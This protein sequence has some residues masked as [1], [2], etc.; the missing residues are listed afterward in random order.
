MIANDT[1]TLLGQLRELCQKLA[2]NDAYNGVGSQANA[3]SGAYAPIITFIE[4]YNETLNDE[5]RAMIPAPLHAEIRR[6]LTLAS[7]PTVNINATQ[8]VQ[9]CIADNRTRLIAAMTGQE[10]ILNAISVTGSQRLEYLT[11]ARSHLLKALDELNRELLSRT[12]CCGQDNLSLN[13]HLLRQLKLPFT[14]ASPRD[15]EMFQGLNPDEMAELLKD[16]SLS[17]QLINGISTLENLILFIMELSTEKTIIFLQGSI[18]AIYP[19]LIAS[20]EDLSALLIS[21]SA[22]KC[23]AVIHGIQSRLQHII[24]RG[25]DFKKTLDHLNP[26]QRVAIIPSLLNALNLINLVVDAYAFSDLLAYLTPVQRTDVYERLKI[27]LPR[28]IETTAKLD[29]GVLQ[30]SCHFFL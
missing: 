1:G 7:D 30:G 13:P 8:N 22:E 27:Q 14:I 29:H 15:L 24:K 3:G 19:I 25:V 10:T 9:T 6:F 23:A 5:A 16:S 20:P 2:V 28:L 26:D 11:K 21:L 12:Y 4:Y 18:A 17:F